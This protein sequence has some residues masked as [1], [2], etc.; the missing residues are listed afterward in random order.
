MA[1]TIRN[2][3]AK[4]T[5]VLHDAAAD[6]AGKT[7][8]PLR[9]T[10]ATEV[11]RKRLVLSDSDSTRWFNLL[12]M[13]FYRN[14][15]KPEI[16]T[17]P[18][19]SLMEFDNVFVTGSEALIFSDF[20]NRIIADESQVFILS[21][22]ARR[23]IRWLAKR[24]T[25]PIFPMGG[26]GTG[27]RG[28]FLIEHLP[29]LLLARRSGQCPPNLRLLLTPGHE[30]WQSEYL[31]LLGEKQESLLRGSHGSILCKTLLTVPSLSEGTI[32]ELY[33]TAVY[34][35]IRKRFLASCPDTARARRRIF[36]SRSD[37]SSRR[38]LNES[39]VYAA[40]REFWPDLELVTL[41]GMSLMQQIALMQETAFLIGPH[42]QSFHLNLFLADAWSIQLVPGARNGTNEYLTWATNYDRLGLVARNRCISF[43]AG[44]N[45]TNDD[46]L[47]P[48]DELRR[49]L[50]RLK[51][52]NG[53]LK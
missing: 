46:W 18:V 43:F 1:S 47:Y 23:P 27:N 45:V 16:V 12:E 19:A 36:I 15:A 49:Y 38:L 7:G 42:G 34:A 32:A 9:T 10:A 31:S 39:E 2:V 8:L 41:S 50:G 53:E 4:I 13:L 22:K 30:S 3:S 29:R 14:S 6:V 5:K 51:R 35:E 11:A 48:I 26:R 25:G 24:E 52:L 17:H 37:A 40:C 33:K 20:W 28:H 21:R 44:P